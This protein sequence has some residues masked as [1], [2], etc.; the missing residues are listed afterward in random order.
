[1]ELAPGVEIGDAMR[2]SVAAGAI[3]EPDQR[4]ATYA[5][6]WLD[7]AVRSD[8]ALRPRV[9]DA[10]REMATGDDPAARAAV[11]DFFATSAVAHWFWPAAEAILAVEPTLASTSLRALQ[12]D[13]PPTRLADLATALKPRFDGLQARAVLLWTELPKPTLITA[14]YLGEVVEALRTAAD[15]GG[16]GS[17]G[18]L[19]AAAESSTWVAAWLPW[20]VAQAE[21]A[22]QAVDLAP[23]L[24]AT[25]AG[26]GD[27]GRSEP[28]SYSRQPPA[29]S[30]RGVVR[31]GGHVLRNVADIRA[32]VAASAAQA[33]QRRAT[34]EAAPRP[35]GWLHRLLR[36]H[37]PW[38]PLVDVALEKLVLRA[39]GDVAWL[40]EWAL[41]RGG[42][43]A[44]VPKTVAALR[45]IATADADAI[46]RALAEAGAGGAGRGPGAS[47]AN[48]TPRSAQEAIALARR[49]LDAPNKRPYADALEAA[50]RQRQSWLREDA[51]VPGVPI[52]LADLF[53]QLADE[54]A[55]QALQAPVIPGPSW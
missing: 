5:L 32:A 24:L 41:E 8:P 21:G 43:T 55:W 20:I 10:L 12:P 16:L 44:H 29:A 36:A 11:V 39:D 28:V 15:W 40:V 42:A 9:A 49:A 31:F 18:W 25:A 4:S 50:L 23:W 51:G 17:L 26:R 45:R 33:G 47:G 30:E 34:G 13:A 46:T 48:P 52:S 54:A 37:P 38:R 6:A 19:A 27:E 1:M 22:D 7:D 35:L 14:H 3:H 2:A 53:A